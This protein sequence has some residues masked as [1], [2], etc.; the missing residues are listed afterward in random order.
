MTPSMQEVDCWQTA[1]SQALHDIWM[2]AGMSRPSTNWLDTIDAML[3]DFEELADSEFYLRDTFRSIGFITTVNNPSLVFADVLDTVI[4]KQR[5]YG[6]GNILRFG[7]QGVVV[8]MSDK[9]ER[10]KNLLR[11]GQKPAYEAIDDTA[12]DIVGYSMIALMLIDGSFEK[13][14]G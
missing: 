2:S 4:G 9:V 11:S 1:A 12:L 14:L 5:D 6:H 10:L 3:P 13:E 7:L 8:R